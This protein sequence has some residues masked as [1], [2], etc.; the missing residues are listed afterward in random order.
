MHICTYTVNAHTL[1]PN[2]M[3]IH[4]QVHTNTYITHFITILVGQSLGKQLAESHS[5][6]FL[7]TAAIDCGHQPRKQPAHVLPVADILYLATMC[8]PGAIF[9]CSHSV[10]STFYSA[11]VDKL[12]LGGVCYFDMNVFYPV[13]CQDACLE[14]M[15]QQDTYW[16]V[17][18][19]G[20]ARCW[21][22]R[23]CTSDCVVV[24][25]DWLIKTLN[26]FLFWL[27]A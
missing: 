20:L 14:S 11:C 13:S 22:V 18:S 4:V 26:T 3:H 9:A 25:A 2:L 23:Q 15:G 6:G 8:D 5:G 10:P 24:T 17:K 1:P 16:P 19:D 27:M 12:H 7:Y 21:T